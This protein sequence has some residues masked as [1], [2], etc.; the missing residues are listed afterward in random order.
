MD[1][2]NNDVDWRDKYMT[3][4]MKMDKKY[5]EGFQEGRQDGLQQGQLKMLMKLV[6]SGE[7]TIA[8]AACLAGVKEDEFVVFL[9]QMKNQ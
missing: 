7:M 5:R 1:L 3:L 2:L 9:E 6:E 8:R 4:E